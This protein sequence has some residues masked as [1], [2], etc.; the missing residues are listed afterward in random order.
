V[1][2]A[3]LTVLRPGAGWAATG[4]VTVEPHG[5]GGVFGGRQE[6]TVRGAAGARWVVRDLW[7]ATVASGTRAVRTELPPGFYT[8]RVAGVTCPF[9]VLRPYAA[10]ADTPFGVN[11]HLQPPAV[12]ALLTALGTTWAR[13][14]LTWTDIEPPPLAGWTPWVYQADASVELDPTVAHSGHSSVKIVNRT[15]LQDDHFATIAQEVTVQPG[16][17]YSFSAWVK[18]E[19]VRALQFT[20]RPDWGS[21]I[22]APGGTF[23]WTEVK[24]QYTT[25]T[26]STLTFRLLS[27]D[28][29]TAAWLDD[30]SMTAAGSSTNLL[31]NPGFESGL[32]SG[33]TFATFDPYLDAL[34]GAGI[35]P[36]PI[37]D[38]ANPKYDGGQTP[39]TDAGRAAFAAY[40]TATLEH[41][42]GRFTAVEV[43][44][45]FN[46]GWFTDGPADGDP[47]YY[48]A[49]LASTY[50]AIKAV[51]SGIAVVG[52]VTYGTAVDWL[53]AVLDAGGRDHLDVVSNHPYTGAPEQQDEQPVLDLVAP[54][55]LW[56]SE[57]GW[58]LADELTTAG[59]LV[60]GLALALT[61]GVQKFFWYDLVGDQ[62]YGLL[63]Q[64]GDDY[65]PRPAYVAYATAIRLLTGRTLQRSGPY[66]VGDA[67]LSVLWTTDVRTPVAVATSRPLTLHDVVGTAT[68]LT[69]VNGHVHLTL[70]G[71]PVYL[72][73][74]GV[75]AASDRLDVEA[76]QLVRT[77]D[78]PVT[79]TYRLGTGG[80]PLTFTTQGVATVVLPGSS[81]QAAVP[82]DDPG[83][84]TL[85]TWVTDGSR[86]VGRLV[87]TVVVIAVPD[88][89]IATIGT[90]DWS[91]RGLALAP[92]GYAGFP[93]GDVHFTLGTD[94]PAQSWP[95][96]HPGPDDGWAGG[97]AHTFTLTVPL[98]AVPG[99][100]LHLVVFLLDTHNTA[101]GTLD[102]ALNGGTPAG[103]TLP[104]GSGTGATAG[105]ALTSG[106]RPSQFTVVLPKARLI[107]GDNVVT[108][109]KSS[110]SWLVYDAVGLYRS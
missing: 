79:L 24:F 40:V 63:D 84:N 20:L 58:S 39:Y 86:T 51:D 66:A 88:G 34:A 78:G 61:A 93:A 109:T 15:P 49:L 33:Y 77:S 64:A 108:L 83:R 22:D 44:N 60:R 54:K 92:D 101:P 47:G 17:T 104:A 68:T 1:A 28:V 71:T 25:T 9:A 81:A 72:S 12:V 85:I 110:G 73:P 32:V 13:T 56:I 94:D 106:D 23:D 107:A 75:V 99:T 45:E 96:I 69:P 97:R 74:P 52:G 10:P 19:G 42:R 62:N 90:V 14:D 41:Y 35:N 5:F 80:P 53:T 46:A 26:E 30:V 89:E 57:L 91:D 50:D 95:Y 16:T 105:D 7:G 76:P 2:G 18:G 65:R 98:D 59:Y 29:T 103:I 48:A 11:T 87:S 37:V 102:V 8:L 43:Y 4:R 21:R 55:P 36:L 82:L 67:G 31:A 3:A 100:D 6:F 70:T 27:N 38:Y